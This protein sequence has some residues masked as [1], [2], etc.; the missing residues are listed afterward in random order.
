[1]IRGSWGFLEPLV[2]RGI[3]ENLDYRDLSESPDWLVYRD[4]WD[5]SAVPDPPVLLGGVLEL[6]LTTWKVLEALAT[7]FLASEDQKEFRVLLDFLDSQVNPACPDFRAP[8]A[9]KAFQE[10]TV[11]R[12]WTV[13]PDRRE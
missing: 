7:D 11:N 8:K 13:S 12:A 9:A 2:R 10:E 1:M 3:E 5:R 4:Q 6:D